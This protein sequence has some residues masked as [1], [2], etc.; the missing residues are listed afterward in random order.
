M[1]AEASD[2]PEFS[3]HRVD[4]SAEIPMETDQEGFMHAVSALFTSFS[5][6][7]GGQLISM[8]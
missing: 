3:V 4:P 8:D 1:R 2:S 7:H 5:I 6:R